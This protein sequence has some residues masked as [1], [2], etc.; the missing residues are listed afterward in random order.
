M[1]LKPGEYCKQGMRKVNKERVA[2]A[3]VK[4]KDDNKKRRKV[5]HVLKKKKMTNR[6]RRRVL[7]TNEEDFKRF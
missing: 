4:A 6:K 7:C 3:D 1:N 5:L 2:K